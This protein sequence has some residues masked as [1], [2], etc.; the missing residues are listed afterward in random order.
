MGIVTT[1]KNTIFGKMDI[2]LPGIGIAFKCKFKSKF[3]I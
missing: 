2:R 3:I 1:D